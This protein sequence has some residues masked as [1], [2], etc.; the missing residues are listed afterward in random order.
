M[1]SSFSPSHSFSIQLGGSVCAP[2]FALSAPVQTSYLRIQNWDLLVLN[3]FHLVTS[4]WHWTNCCPS[5]RGNSWRSPELDYCSGTR[6]RS[7]EGKEEVEASGTVW[8]HQGGGARETDKE[9]KAPC[10]REEQEQQEE[11]GEW[12]GFTQVC[13]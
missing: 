4:L 13:Q 5:L 11:D 10:G 1:Q 7:K 3:S 9:E 6:R 2:S 12:G 8:W